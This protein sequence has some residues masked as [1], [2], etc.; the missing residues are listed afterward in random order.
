MTVQSALNPVVAS[1]SK[2]H[3]SP[4]Q[5]ISLVIPVF[6]EAAGLKEVLHSIQVELEGWRIPVEVIVVDDGSQDGC[7]KLMEEFPDFVLLQHRANRG[8]GAALKTG[9]RQ[10]KFP[11]ICITDGDGTYPVEQI[12]G[13]IQMQQ[14][15]GASMIIGARSQPGAA[16][17][18]IRRPAKWALNRVGAF[19]SGEPIPDLNS[20]LRLFRRDLAQQIFGMLPDGFS[21]TSTL[22]LALVTNGFQVGYLPIQYHLRQGTSKIRPVVDT[23]NFLQTILRM[24]LYFAP[25]KVFLPLSGVMI[26]AAVVWALLTRFLLGELADVSTLILA[27]AGIQVALLGMLAELI[28]RRLPGPFS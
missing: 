9:I 2:A 17:P 19:I 16:I 12:P 27:V 1:A 21:F 28:N 8:Y 14:K 3:A 11:W 18:R 20:G 23:V 4:A 13:L 15:S 5:G 10:A 6:N 24:A 25:L 26:A 22:T 7:Q